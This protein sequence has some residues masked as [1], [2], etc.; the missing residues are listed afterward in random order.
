MVLHLW[1]M[2]TYSPMEKR[3]TQASA[4]LGRDDKPEKRE[5][6]NPSPYC[7]ESPTL[8]K[9]DEPEQR[10]KLA[11][12]LESIVLTSNERRVNIGTKL[13]VEKRKNLINFLRS[14]NPFHNKNI[15]LLR[16]KSNNLSRSRSNNMSR[17]RRN[18]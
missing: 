11:K 14:N 9:D 6:A 18:N 3:P 7:M 2:T 4:T 8:G 12:D 16:F 17:S 5:K 15:N 10:G 1:R 13:G